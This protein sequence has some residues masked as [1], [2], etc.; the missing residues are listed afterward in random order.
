MM[1]NKLS[2][3]DPVVT[4]VSVEE[5]SVGVGS[6]IGKLI[7][8]KKVYLTKLQEIDYMVAAN[9]LSSRYLEHYAADVRR[10]FYV[11]VR[12]GFDDQGEILYLRK[13]L[14]IADSRARILVNQF[15]K[16]YGLKLEK[17]D[18]SHCRRNS[19]QVTLSVVD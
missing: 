9:S 17:F 7:A 14:G 6:E 12:S 1:E 10:C 3:K 15:L 11:I 13:N 19:D 16:E 8:R 18:I 4:A 2:I 5:V